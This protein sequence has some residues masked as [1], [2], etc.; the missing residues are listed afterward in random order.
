[1]LGDFNAN[2]QNPMHTVVKALNNFV[3]FLIWISW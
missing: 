1:M 3:I 2:Y